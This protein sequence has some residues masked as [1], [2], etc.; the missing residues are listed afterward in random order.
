MSASQ[1]KALSHC[2]QMFLIA[3]NIFDG[4]DHGVSLSNSFPC[5]AL[6]SKGQI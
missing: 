4:Y 6:K 3:E 2:W 1:E 5:S